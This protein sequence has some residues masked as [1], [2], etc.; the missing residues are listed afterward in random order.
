APLH[1]RVA[2]LELLLDPGRPLEGLAGEVLA[3]G[4]DGLAR[5]RVERDDILF[6]LRGLE[7]EALLGGADVRD[8]ALDVLQRLELLLVGIVEC[9]V[10]ILCAI[11]QRAELR[12]DNLAS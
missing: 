4:S 2:T 10:R 11:E 7:L 6:E 5:L 1:R 9:L 8:S 12:P 3:I